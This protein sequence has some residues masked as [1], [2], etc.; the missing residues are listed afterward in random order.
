MSHWKGRWQPIS[1]L[2]PMMLLLVCPNGAEIWN[3]RMGA[4]RGLWRGIQDRFAEG[5]LTY[6]IEKRAMKLSMTG[7]S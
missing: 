1:L 6:T 5:D 7:F 3:W 2:E 4:V